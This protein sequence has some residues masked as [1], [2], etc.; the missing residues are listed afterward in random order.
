MPIR[1]Q[2]TSSYPHFYSQTELFG[3]GNP[4]FTTL[5]INST[6]NLGDRPFLNILGAKALTFMGL[7]SVAAAGSVD[8][9]FTADAYNPGD[10]NISGGKNYIFQAVNIPNVAPNNG[11][12]GFTVHLYDDREGYISIVGSSDYTVLYSSLVPWCFGASNGLALNLVS[13]VTSTSALNVVRA[14]LTLR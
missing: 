11:A 5:N 9:S 7:F 6:L 4:V 1:L 12:Y 8:L 3:V 13:A 14:N 10:I 2:P